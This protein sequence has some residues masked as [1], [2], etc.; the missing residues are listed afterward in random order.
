MNLLASQTRHKMYADHNIRD[1]TFKSGECV[2]LKV[3]P[4]KVV[5]RVD[6]N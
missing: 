4:M 6:M 2:H 5:I 1:I 3:S